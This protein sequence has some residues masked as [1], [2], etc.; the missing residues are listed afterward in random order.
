L[1]I[2]AEDEEAFRWACYHGHLRLARWLYRIK[3]SI[4]ISA[5]DEWAFQMACYKGH[6]RVAQWIRSL[7][8]IHNNNNKINKSKTIMYKDQIDICSICS[9]TECNLQ[10]SCN[11]TFCESCIQTWFNSKQDKICPCC[12][13]CLNNTVFQPIM[14]HP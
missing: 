2:S 3:P 9:E 12:R 13:S 5:N 14:K 11:H 8:S 7:N 1:D 6:L 10:T 4:N